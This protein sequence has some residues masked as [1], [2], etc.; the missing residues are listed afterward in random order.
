MAPPSTILHLLR[1]K[2]TK[3]NWLRE[4]I[5]HP[6]RARYINKRAANGIATVQQVLRAVAGKLCPVLTS[7]LPVISPR[8]GPAVAEALP[9]IADYT[10]I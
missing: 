5:S 7:G 1:A 2:K 8:R 6:R 9:R 4:E 3:I 10:L